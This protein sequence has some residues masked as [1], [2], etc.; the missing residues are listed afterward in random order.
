MYN[1]KMAKE[2]KWVQ[3]KILELLKVKITDPD[4]PVTYIGPSRLPEYTAEAVNVHRE[5]ILEISTSEEIDWDNWSSQRKAGVEAKISRCIIAHI[6]R[7][8]GGANEKN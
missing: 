3:N 4:F 6:K 7:L 1:R 5:I 2:N 8:K